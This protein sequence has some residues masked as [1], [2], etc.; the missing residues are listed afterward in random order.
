MS[1]GCPLEPVI[2]PAKPDPLAGMTAGIVASSY[3]NIAEKPPAGRRAAIAGPPT[4]LRRIGLRVAGAGR[5]LGLLLHETGGDD[6]ALVEEDQRQRERHLAD[7][8]GRGE[9][10]GQDEG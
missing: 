7:D 1:T 8:V 9:H 4:L 5:G 6:R 10:R 3:T 2:G